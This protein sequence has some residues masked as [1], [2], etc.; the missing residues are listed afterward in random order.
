MTNAELLAKIKA[1]IERR[2]KR[3]K[4]EYAPGGLFEVQDNLTKLLSFLDTIESEKTISP[5]KKIHTY[6]EEIHEGDMEK[7]LLEL[8]VGKGEKRTKIALP[9]RIVDILESEKPMNPDRDLDKE[10]NRFREIFRNEC[11]AR[12]VGEIAN[13]FAK[14]GAE[15]AKIDVTDFCK[16]ID[17]GIAQCIADHSWEMLG[18]DEK[19]VPNDLEEAAEDFV[20][21][22]MEND[23][24]GISD[25]CRKLRPTSKISDFYDALAEFFIAGAKWQAEQLLKSSPLPEDTILFNKGVAEGRRL[26]MEE[27]SDHIAAAYQLGLAANNPNIELKAELIHTTD[28][29]Q[30][31]GK[32]LLYV[33]DKS[34]K[35]GWRDCRERIV[36][37]IE[38]RLSEIIGDAQPKP[39][40]RMELKELITK[41]KEAKK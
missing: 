12:I 40:L 23:E 11:D 26:M 36:S 19:P 13:H 39:I 8:S 7:M 31:D 38:S 34:Y 16:P 18:E 10:I 15:H 3:N 30:V 37:L 5:W 32:E 24:D 21:E 14:W 6:T 33:S 20:W 29:A 1:E 9:D 27:L 2:I 41:I 22:V 4:E 25:L 35:I 28:T 17:P